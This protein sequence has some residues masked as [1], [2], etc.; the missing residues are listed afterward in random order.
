M[1]SLLHLPRPAPAGQKQ[2]N[3]FPNNCPILSPPSSIS[4]FDHHLQSPCSTTETGQGSGEAKVAKRDPWEGF[5]ISQ[6]ERARTQLERNLIVKDRGTDSILQSLCRRAPWLIPRAEAWTS[7][8]PCPTALCIAKDDM[9]TA[10]EWCPV[11]A[12]T[13][14][15]EADADMKSLASAPV[16]ANYL[17][18]TPGQ[19][20]SAKQHYARILIRNPRPGLLNIRRCLGPLTTKTKKG[21]RISS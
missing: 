21:G 9:A 18:P 17:W 15:A 19:L 3:S 2:P 1:L 5:T 13:L 6:G 7:G 8:Y 4:S 20:H 14:W 11:F 10:C 12:H 16:S